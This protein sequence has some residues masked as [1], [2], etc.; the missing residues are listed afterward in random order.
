MKSLAAVFV[1]LGV[2]LS[3]LLSTA[4]TLLFSYDHHYNHHEG[5]TT[6]L[7]SH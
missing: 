6:I 5:T 1:E 7:P 2:A 3:S 4:S